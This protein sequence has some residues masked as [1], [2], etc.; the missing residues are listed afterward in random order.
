MGL[1]G[2]TLRSTLIIGRLCSVLKAQKLK[3]SF[4]DEPSTNGKTIGVIKHIIV[5]SMFIRELL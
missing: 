4:V 3:Y 1:H 5:L 2:D